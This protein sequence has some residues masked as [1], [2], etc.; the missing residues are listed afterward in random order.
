[1]LQHNTIDA[2]TEINNQDVTAIYLLNDQTLQINDIEVPLQQL[3]YTAK[4]SDNINAIEHEI[5][6]LMEIY[7]Q[8]KSYHLFILINT[9][10]LDEAMAHKI[11]RLKQQYSDNIHFIYYSDNNNLM[12]HLQ[13]IRHH[14]EAFLSYPFESGEI[15]E[16]IKSLSVIEPQDYRIL[17]IDDDESMGIYYS[18]VF[19]KVGI[20]CQYEKSIEFILDKVTEFKPDLILIDYY[21]PECSGIELTQMMRQRIDIDF[22]PIVYLSSETDPLIHLE[23]ITQGVDDFLYKG[24]HSKYIISNLKSRMDRARSLKNSMMTDSLTHLY[25]HAMINEQFD[26]ELAKAQRRSTEVSY[27]MIDI[28]NFKQV[29]DTYGHMAGDKVIKTLAHFL[30][31]KLRKTD[32]VGRYGGEEF[33]VIM[34]DTT[35][36]DAYRV[37]DKLR[38]DFGQISHTY[39]AT[40]FKVSFSCGI[41]SFPE[42]IEQDN[43]IEHADQCLYLAKEKGRNQV[44]HFIN[45]NH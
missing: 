5:F 10:V 24:T 31:N 22:I 4:I 6:D 42:N 8:Y 3:G 9:M 36:Y 44:V 15:S 11:D 17:L 13:G 14:G 16:I 43:I 41:A 28:D 32:I 7:N 30:T 45:R 38:K 1:M 26:L 40:S 18:H 29:N 34:P 27:V 20:E 25:N 2:Q 12:S 19:H 33:A 37:I 35:K 39:E 21:M 23:S